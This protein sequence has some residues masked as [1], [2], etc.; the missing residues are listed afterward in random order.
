MCA[1]WPLAQ[2]LPMCRLPMGLPRLPGIVPRSL[3]RFSHRLATGPAAGRSGLH[4]Q[5][6]RRR[7]GN[8]PIL[9]PYS[10]YSVD[11]GRRLVRPVAEP[12]RSRRLRGRRPR[13]AR[14]YDQPGPGAA[15]FR[16]GGPL[17]ADQEVAAYDLADRDQPAQ[18]S[19][20]PLALNVSLTLPT[21][22]KAGAVG[23]RL[24]I[25]RRAARARRSD[26]RRCMVV[27]RK[28]R[29]DELSARR[30][31]LGDVEH[32]GGRLSLAGR[33]RHRGAGRV[34]EYP[35][36]GAAAVA[37]DQ[38]WTGRGRGADSWPTTAIQQHNASPCSWAPGVAL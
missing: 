13:A 9:V 16:G 24:V 14:P 6:L 23:P 22:D 2:L 29:L 35:Q 11:E 32:Y 10:G 17:L 18:L 7:S 38:A 12:L 19:G 3:L 4:S 31:Q 25:R 20:A 8:E 21:G 33:R 28:L 30:L 27:P 36:A 37:A 15:R 1:V 26:Q 5:R 34:A